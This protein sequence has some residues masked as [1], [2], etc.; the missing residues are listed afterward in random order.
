M[1]LTTEKSQSNDDSQD[2]RDFRL[3]VAHSMKATADL[4][5]V[6]K[7]LEQRDRD[8]KQQSS[9]LD[10]LREVDP[11]VIE[12]KLADDARRNAQLQASKRVIA[13]IDSIARRLI[14]RVQILA[15]GYSKRIRD[16][17]VQNL[18]AVRRWGHEKLSPL[19][20]ELRLRGVV[21]QLEVVQAEFRFQM[22]H[23]F[24]GA[25]NCSYVVDTEQPGG[26]RMDTYN[27]S[28]VLSAYDKL[29]D[30]A[31]AVDLHTEELRERLK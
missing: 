27:L 14:P 16:G 4:N 22:L 21:D 28:A 7:E 2:V 6:N 25:W 13:S 3:V 31:S 29:R 12:K 11:K 24:E 18:A 30:S 26:V 8:E 1:K 15:D 20:A 23:P 9:D 5:A 17:H 19:F 10:I